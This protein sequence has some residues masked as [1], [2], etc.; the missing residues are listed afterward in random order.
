MRYLVNS[1]EMRQ[2]DKWTSE[3]FKMPP[4]LLMEQAAL[5]GV[6]EL[7]KVIEK[8]KKIVIVCGV[9]NNGGDGFAMAR[10]LY[11]K[12]YQVDVVLVGD[13]EKASEQNRKQQEILFAYGVKI[14]EKIPTEVSY[15][16]IVD[17]IFGVGL[18]RDIGEPYKSIIEEMNEKKAFKV[19]LDVPSG[20]SVDDGAVLGVAFK[21]DVT[22]TFAFDKVGLH[23]W[24]GNECCGQIVV[25][26]IGITKES[27]MEQVPQ[28]KAKEQ[29]IPCK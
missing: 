15:G 1:C 24:P 13:K 9:G 29:T 23:L 4:L 3:H 6:E 25:K 5:A 28:I 21:A 17:A 27:F 10:I 22:I 26:E 2:Y 19:A 12:G 11:L 14:H 16:T 18:T 7:E 20:V 8:E